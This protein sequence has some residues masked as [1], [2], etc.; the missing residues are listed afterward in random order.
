MSLIAAC[1]ECAWELV[2]SE[3]PTVADLGQAGKLCREHMDAEHFALW[4]PDRDIRADEGEF[5]P[6]ECDGSG[7]CSAPVHVHGCYRPHRS[8]EC[9]SPDEY[10]HTEREDGGE[11]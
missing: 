8:D 9:D 6:G 2:V 11:R 4:S 3:S 5:A 10:G 1:Q 7:T